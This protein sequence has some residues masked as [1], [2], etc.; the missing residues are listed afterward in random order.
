MD[1]IYGKYNHIVTAKLHFAET[2]QLFF[3][4]LQ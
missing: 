2:G 4:H 1:K 3:K